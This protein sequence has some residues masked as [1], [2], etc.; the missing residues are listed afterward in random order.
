[1]QGRAPLFIFFGPGYFGAAQPTAYAN[2]DA[3]GSGPHAALNGAF[4]GAP[5]IDPGFDLLSHLFAHDVGVQFGFPDLEDVDLDFFARQHFEFFF[6]QVHLFTAFA[7][8]DTGPAGMD[9][10]GY[11][12][13]RTLDDDPA[14]TVLHRFIAIAR[15]GRG[16]FRTAYP[17][18]VADLFVFYDLQT[19][20]FIGVPVR[21]PTADDA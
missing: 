11:T 12:L 13:H 6:D 2:L 5:E 7:D 17:Q 10:H 21:I 8:D 3:F 20:I 9:G 19:V 18:I 14:D 1:M 16:G 15:I 4:H